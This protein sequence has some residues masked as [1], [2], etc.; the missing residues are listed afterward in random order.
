MRI[1]Q[2]SGQNNDGFRGCSA[3]W[4][5]LAF[6]W[7]NVCLGLIGIVVPGMPTTVFMI[8]AFWAFAKSSERFKNWLWNHPRFGASIQAW[9]EHRVIPLRAKILAVAMMSASFLIVTVFIAEDWVLPSLLAL[10]MIPVCAY[11]LS[12]NSTIPETLSVTSDRS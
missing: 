7:V 9:H 3:R 11:L 12:R 1:G 2:D 6:G 4:A 8:V 10:V 5:L